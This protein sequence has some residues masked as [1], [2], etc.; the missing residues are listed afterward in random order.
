MARSRAAKPF[1]DALP[2]MGRDGSL[3]HTGTTLRS[4]G[5]VRA[6]PGTTILAGAD[7][8][9]LELK[10]QNMAGYLDHEVGPPRRVRADGQRRRHDH[11]TS[12][13]TSPPSSKTKPASSTPSRPA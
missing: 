4:R 10:A 3:A 5:N 9:S 1:Y 2:I 11:A 7:G 6:K 12:R 8:E 13:P